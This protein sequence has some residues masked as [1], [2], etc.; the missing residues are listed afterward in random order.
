MA[1]SDLYFNPGVAIGVGT[2][3][4]FLSAVTINAKWFMNF[5]GVIDSSGVL[6]SFVLPGLLSS[7]LSAIFQA[8]TPLEYGNYQP[9]FRKTRTNF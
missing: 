1:I 3:A 7:I 5:N 9:N 4:G 6:S 2:I 8:N